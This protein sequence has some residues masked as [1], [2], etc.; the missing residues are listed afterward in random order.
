[1]L[2]LL[3]TTV[4]QGMVNETSIRIRHFGHS[5]FSITTANGDVIFIDPFGN[6]AWSRWFSPELDTHKADILLISHRHFDH[7][8]REVIFGVRT[9]LDGPGSL[10]GPDYRITGIV[11]HHA[12]AIKY[13]MS[14][15]TIYVI[16]ADGVRICHWG[17][18]DGN[19]TGDQAALIGNPDI[20]MLPIDNSKHIL[21]NVEVSSI[22]HRLKPKIVIPMHYFEANIS[23]CCS[24]LGALS[25]WLGMQKNVR[26]INDAGELIK[27]SALPRESEIWVMASPTPKPSRKLLYSMPCFAQG[28]L[29]WIVVICCVGIAIVIVR[30]RM[31]A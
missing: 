12:H 5:A 20:L 26:F 4:V 10:I 9:V 13:G 29:F 7:D 2:S 25:E 14:K 27:P 21:N 6:S 16:D 22:I 11:G 1:M 31:S 28:A 8:N 17:D 15:N 24:P 23:S 19:I 30:F 3:I 18:N